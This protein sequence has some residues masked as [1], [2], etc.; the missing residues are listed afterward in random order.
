M[1]L[2][3]EKPVVLLK[4][5]KTKDEDESFGENVKIDPIISSA[6]A[7]WNTPEKLLVCP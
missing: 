7:I 5:E 6:T 2:S 1:S 3:L 4:L